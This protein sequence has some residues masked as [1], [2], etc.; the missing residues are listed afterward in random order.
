MPNRPDRGEFYTENGAL[1]STIADER[2]APAWSRLYRRVPLARYPRVVVNAAPDSQPP[3]T[4]ETGTVAVPAPVTPPAQAQP[5]TA[6]GAAPAPLVRPRRSRKVQ[7]LL[8][9]LIVLGGLVVVGG[10][11]GVILY[12]QATKIDR[13]TPAVT[14]DQF[15]QAGLVEKDAARVG[16]FTCDEWSGPDA[17]AQLL[18]LVGPDVTASWGVVSVPLNDGAQAEAIV[19]VRFSTPVGQQM[20]RVTEVWRVKLADQS[21]WRVCSVTNDPSLQP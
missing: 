1:V 2:S 21:G 18:P 5:P 12:D 4:P 10:A 19:R 13:S 3:V 17:L 14:I 16:L 15:L 20:A 6:E 9:L 11:A 7:V 8:I